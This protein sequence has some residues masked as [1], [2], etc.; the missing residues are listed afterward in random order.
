MRRLMGARILNPR[1]FLNREGAVIA[2]VGIRD[3]SEAS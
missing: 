3:L 2:T 1:I